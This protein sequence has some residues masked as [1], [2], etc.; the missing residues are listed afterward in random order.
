MFAYNVFKISVMNDI[1]SAYVGNSIPVRGIEAEISF[2]QFIFIN[3]LFIQV[4]SLIEMPGI[5]ATK[6][7]H[8][9]NVCECVFACT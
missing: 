6:V 7:K 8:V 3:A 4:K 2:C 1:K 9:E 5:M